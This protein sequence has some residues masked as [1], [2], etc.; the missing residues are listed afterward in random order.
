MRSRSNSLEDVAKA[1]LAQQPTCSR[2]RAAE[3]EEPSGRAGGRT[4]HREPPDDTG[5]VQRNHKSGRGSASSSA[6]GNATQ[7]EKVASGKGRDLSRDDLLFLLSML[8]GELQV[9]W[10]VGTNSL[11]AVREIQLVE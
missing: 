10:E 8:E 5:T 3:R 4:R 11:G 6:G 9:R 1:K 2:R 7:K